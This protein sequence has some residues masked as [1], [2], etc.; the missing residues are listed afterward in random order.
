MERFKDQT[1][2]IVRR[3]YFRWTGN[4]TGWCYT[5]FCSGIYSSDWLFIKLVFRLPLKSVNVWYGR[6]VN[7][8][9]SETVKAGLGNAVSRQLFQLTREV[10]DPLAEPNG[11]WQREAGQSAQQW[12]YSFTS[13]RISIFLPWPESLNI[14]YESSRNPFAVPSV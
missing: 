6:L 13:F 8:K 4:Q 5:S 1:G 9:L 3:L 7:P 14:E 12:F 11:D 10:I 2:H